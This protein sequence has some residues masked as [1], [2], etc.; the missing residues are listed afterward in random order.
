MINKLS[1]TITQLLVNPLIYS[2]GLENYVTNKLSRL[3]I[4]TS[5]RQTS[6]LSTNTAEELNQAISETNPPAG[7]SSHVAFFVL[8]IVYSVLFPLCVIFPF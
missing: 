5:R 4:L 2:V 6:W 3:T 8:K 1:Y 7:Q